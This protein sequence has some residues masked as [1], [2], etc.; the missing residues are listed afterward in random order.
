[1][2]EQSGIISGQ[3]DLTQVRGFL[4][5]VD[6]TLS[7]TDDHL[8]ERIARRLH[9]LAWLWKDRDPRRFARWFVM[10][11]ESPANAL[12]SLADRL[13]LDAYLP[14]LYDWYSRKR[15]G[16]SPTHDRFRIVPGVKALL[17]ELKGRYPLAVVSARDRNTTMQFL[18]HFDLMRYFEVIVTAQTCQHTKPFPDPVFY[19]AQALGLEAKQ[20]VMV[21]DTIVDVVAGRSA[22]AQTMAVL[23][24]FGT[25][26]ELARAGADL[27][28]S[29]TAEIIQLF[30]IEL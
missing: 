2:T 20:C 13:H 22:G 24:G 14:K 5:D 21:G 10:T 6:G 7:D 26:R 17:D 27:I 11:A 29:S 4:F 15:H 8:V 18:E 25:Q 28:I 30:D 1:M 16:K 19:A 9:L 12:Y 3:I 23:C